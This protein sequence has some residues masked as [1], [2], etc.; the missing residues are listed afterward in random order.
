M[1]EKDAWLTTRYYVSF[2]ISTNKLP[3]SQ[4]TFLQDF[5]TIQKVTTEQI[6]LIDNLIGQSLDEHE[7]NNLENK[8]LIV[9]SRFLT[10]FLKNDLLLTEQPWHDNDFLMNNAIENVINKFVALL[11]NYQDINYT[12][13][14]LNQI[15]KD[16]SLALLPKLLNN[17]LRLPLHVVIDF[18][19]GKL[20]NDYIASGLNDI[21]GL[22]ITIDPRI[23]A[24]TDI[25]LTD[26]FNPRFIKNQIIWDTIPKQS[27]WRQLRAFIL[28]LQKNR[29]SQLTLN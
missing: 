5:P 6:N 8:L 12:A 16:Y 19:E 27:D 11:Q 21:S 4:L 18:S 15:K 25:Y 22:N 29:F 14:E 7:L 10:P 2:F 23:D 3:V 17:K 26:T 20:L 13:V 24:L 1:L 9:N 28:Y